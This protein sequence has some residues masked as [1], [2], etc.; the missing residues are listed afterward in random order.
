MKKK[1]TTS[2]FQRKYLRYTI[3]LLLLALLLSIAGVWFYVRRNM[4][5]VVT[6][7]YAFLNEKAG[8]ALDALFQ[9]SDKVTEECILNDL[10]Q[11]SLK[12][13][14]LE[15]VE[16]NS[17]SKYFAYVD[18]NAVSEYC[19]ADNKGNLYTRSYSKIGYADFAGSGL[20]EKLGDSYARTKWIFTE[21]TLFGNGKDDGKKVLFIGRKVHSLSYA[22]EPGY[23]FFKMDDGFWEELNE[24]ADQSVDVAMGIMDPDGNICREWYPDSFAMSDGL[25][26]KL[27][28]YAGNSSGAFSGG[29]IAENVRAA[30]DV[31]SVYRQAE[32]GFCVFTIVPG[33]VLSKET[34]RIFLVLLCIYVLVIM[35]AVVLS[36][37]FSNRITRPITIL[38]QAMTEFNGENFEK[39]I[40]LNTHTELDQ[41]GN[42]Y[43]KMLENIRMLLD[44]I[45]AQQKELRTS[46]LNMLISQVNPHFLYNTLDTIY[47]LAR[48]NK[49][50]TTMKMIQALSKY[51][52]L[53]LNKGSD[54]V[55]V[56]DELEN[57]KSYLQIQQIRNENLFTYEVECMVDAQKTYVLKLILQPIVENAVKYGF[58]EIYEG[59]QI[60]IRVYEEAKKRI[61]TVYNNG[62][63]MDQKMADKINTLNGQPLSEARK[64]FLN[65]KNGY[66]V[67]NVMTRLRLK[68]GDETELTY[69][70][71]EEEGTLCR[72]AIP[73]LPEDTGEKKEAGRI[74][75]D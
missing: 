48:I 17:L 28:D 21:D 13:P 18:L 42:S 12:T 11:K 75:G 5:G 8:I 3:G 14:D 67:I 72:I 7:K 38:N 52:R 44:E 15:E 27:E 71:L 56:A 9:K 36:I 45:K 65:Q 22:H 66:G 31:L 35:I 29:V 53:S 58:C 63:P 32:S 54:M 55:S 1:R 47:M 50:E 26:Q 41:I 49:E 25:W 39:L 61:F 62:T 73:I 4:M 51:L 59:G 2:G 37:Y 57:V 34:S 16:K 43:N 60:R 46:E 19:Y 20:V 10:V 69:Q 68:Y 70:V 24:E 33:K 30:G 64:S 6:D 74:N 40:Q 23:L